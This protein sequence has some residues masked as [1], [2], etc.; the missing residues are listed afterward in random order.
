MRN[1]WKSIGISTALILFN[2]A[3]MGIMGTTMIA[4]WVLH[5]FSTLIIGVIIYGILLSGGT[6]LAERGIRDENLGMAAIG[7]ALLQI[8]YGSFG[9]AMLG[10]APTNLFI[11]IL[12]VTAF[13]T[14]IIA[15]AAA[16]LVY[17]TKRDFSSF[18]RYSTYLF[19]GVLLTAFVGTFTPVVAGIAFILA[20]LG[21]LTLLVYEI[22]ETRKSPEK[23]LLNGIG[24]YNAFMGVFVHIL[25]I[26]AEMYLRR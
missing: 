19:L 8:G 23:V 21:F 16:A 26:V 17:G 2:V 24:I 10:Y 6:Y 5:L 7:V 22:W 13:V 25:R 3:L 14:G 1:E 11:P 15:V 4:D 18:R 9:A 20:L 12:A